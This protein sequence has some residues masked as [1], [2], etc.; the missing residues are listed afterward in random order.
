MKVGGIHFAPSDASDVLKVSVPRSKLTVMEQ[1]KEDEYLVFA[2][3]Y[4]TWL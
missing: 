2:T 3:S 4:S 1:V